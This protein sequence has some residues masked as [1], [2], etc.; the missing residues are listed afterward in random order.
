MR[1]GSAAIALVAWLAGCNALLGLDAGEPADTSSTSSG[2][3]AASG[4][5]SGTTSSSAG[6][7][8]ASTGGGNPSAGG[9]GASSM[10]G[11]GGDG[12][13]SRGGAGGSGGQSA[14]TGCGPGETCNEGLAICECGSDVASMPA[15]QA[16]PDSDQYPACVSDARGTRCGCE[17]SSCTGGFVCDTTTRECF[18]TDG[19]CGPLGGCWM[20]APLTGLCYH[21][22]T[23]ATYGSVVISGACNCTDAAA[24]CE[25]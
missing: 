12:G 23:C 3:N 9:G 8:A 20:A 10:G 17:A 18:C 24:S 6:G 19:G 15:E 13:G 16:C 21:D 2:G 7:G 25:D 11:S 4:G 22:S 14:C 1:A 5:S